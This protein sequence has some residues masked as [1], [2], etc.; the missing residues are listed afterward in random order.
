MA[1]LGIY[2]I[3]LSRVILYAVHIDATEGRRDTCF[4][5]LKK[6][7]QEAFEAQLKYNVIAISTVALQKTSF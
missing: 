5:F 3:I 1:T 4:L 6:K 2:E 7:K